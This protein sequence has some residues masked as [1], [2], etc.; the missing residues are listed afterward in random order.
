MGLIQMMFDDTHPQ[1]PLSLK[2][3][4]LRAR[5]VLPG[6]GSQRAAIVGRPR[7][8]PK[9]RLQ[10]AQLLPQFKEFCLKGVAQ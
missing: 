6:W 10:R 7:C 5:P 4:K 9:I 1:Q 2:V 8:P 3:G